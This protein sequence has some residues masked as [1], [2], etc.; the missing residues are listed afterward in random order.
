MY[1]TEFPMMSLY[2][3]LWVF[4]FFSS[5][6][7]PLT[8]P[9]C[10]EDF[11]KLRRVACLVFRC[12][13]F[14]CFNVATHIASEPDC[15]PSRTIIH[16]IILVTHC[17][18]EVCCLRLS[19]I[20]LFYFKVCQFYCLRFWLCGGCGKVYWEGKMFVKARRGETQPYFH[21]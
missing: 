8:C 4:V 3:V 18:V 7:F 12:Y 17:A 6:R 14:L 9:G 16:S 1:F 13:I 2:Y 10:G 21:R 11:G 15:R 5:A 19:H 20:I